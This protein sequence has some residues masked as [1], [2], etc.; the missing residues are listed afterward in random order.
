MSVINL[1][2]RLL[3]GKISSVDPVTNT[4]LVKLLDKSKEITCFLGIPFMSANAGIRFMPVGG[5]T[6]VLG[7]NPAGV[8]TIVSF[9]LDPDLVKLWESDD[10]KPEDE[11]ELYKRNLKPGDIRLY[12]GN[13]EAEVYLSSDGRVEVCSG[14]A[15][16]SLD[17]LRHAVEFIS[18]TVKWSLL[19]GVN[20][21]AGFITR[22]IA[23][24]EQRIPGMVEY[25]L[26]IEKVTGKIAS[27]KMGDVV[28]DYG[29]PEVGVLSL[30]KTF[31]LKTYAGIV[32][33][34]EVYMDLSGEVVVSGTTI[35]LGGVLSSFSLVRG[36]TLVTIITQLV[37]SI[38]TAFGAT[39][40]KEGMDS[41]ILNSIASMTST[42]AIL[43]TVLSPTVKVL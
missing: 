3:F 10:A 38:I 39:Q 18:N 34:G 9:I 8:P 30:P 4:C 37:N 24:V 13:S 21:N 35:R 28:N 43:P 14:M 27:L 12:T 36:E 7:I 5:E 17:S 41:V 2:D 22:E 19:S 33:I 1:Y 40:A 11:R 16:V 26:E 15:V 29:V 32:P 25:N 42:L 23:G 20:M 31:S 6:V